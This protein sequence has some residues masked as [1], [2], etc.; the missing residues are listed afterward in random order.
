MPLATELNVLPDAICSTVMSLGTLMHQS[1]A[2]KRSPN[3]A[4]KYLEQVKIFL[5]KNT[6][7]SKFL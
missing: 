4:K 1:P 7:H 2:G 5:E 6:F 3:P